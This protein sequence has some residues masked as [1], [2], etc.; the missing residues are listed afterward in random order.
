MNKKEE[1]K[2]KFKIIEE[3]IYEITNSS[4]DEYFKNVLK[5]ASK[6]REVIKN[7]KQE[8]EGYYNL[9]NVLSHKKE[10]G[11]DMISGINNEIVEN[12]T[13]IVKKI[14]EPPTAKEVFGK[15]V[16]ETKLDENLLD[17]LDTMKDIENGPYTHI[18]VRDNGRFVGVLS[19]ASIAN[20][21]GSG[22]N[23]EINK[24]TTISDIRDFITDLP[25][26]RFD[27]V[28][29]SDSAYKVK[30]KFS[31]YIKNERRLGVIYVTDG[32]DRDKPFVG[33]ATAWDLESDK[34]KQM[35]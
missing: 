5:E 17:V 7:Y 11:E 23:V 24:K 18:P 19:D 6:R 25:N 15:K 27:F 32:G 21:L 2:D 20:W 34:V 9:R 8:I 28:E 30:N 3:Y 13:K 35:L 31:N 10:L 33:V 12:V 16:I 1:F 26:E 4:Q 14:K 29:D 22:N